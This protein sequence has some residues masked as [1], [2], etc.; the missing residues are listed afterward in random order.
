VGKVE[1]PLA[2]M[3][4]A[5]RKNTVS[6]QKKKKKKKKRADDFGVLWW[7]R[8]CPHAT[9]DKNRCPPCRARPEIF[10]VNTAP[11]TRTR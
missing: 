8:S 6:S 3:M 7:R 2:I 5:P 4:V 11:L 9:K 10:S 1:I